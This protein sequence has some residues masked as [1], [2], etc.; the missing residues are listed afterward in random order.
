NNNIIREIVNV[1]GNPILTTS[2]KT[3]DE[4][5]EYNT[6]PELIYEEYENLVDAVI[7]GGYGGLVASTVIDCTENEFKI[8][9][10][11]NF[12]PEL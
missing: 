11:G 12:E 1:L 7:D 4:I 10:M 2:L 5:I 9:R 6:D 8:V 3:N